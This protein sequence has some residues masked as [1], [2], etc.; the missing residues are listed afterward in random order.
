[1]AVMIKPG[2]DVIY[3]RCGEFDD[4]P[5]TDRV[6]NE[7]ANRFP[8]TIHT[9]QSM[10]IVDCYRQVGHFYIFA[11]TEEEKRADAEY[12]KSFF[13]SI[14]GKANELGC[15]CALIGLR[16]E[17]S[18]RRRILLRSRGN[19]IF[20]KRHNIREVFPL[21]EWT[22]MD[23]WAYIFTNNLPY[24]N[25]YDLATDRERARNGPMFAANIQRRGS[26]LHYAGQL[27]LLKRMYPDLFNRFAVEF[28][29]LRLYV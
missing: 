19:D 22:G 11:E 8:V 9:V 12:E 24:L 25:L 29:E 2:I 1:M 4:W 27:S 3:V 17:E 18:K 26:E 15:D 13:R 14:T 5:D 16:Q 21:S 10:S 23:V 28:P 7:F 20:T 6:M